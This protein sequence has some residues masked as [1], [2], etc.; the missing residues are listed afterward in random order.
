MPVDRVK[1]VNLP[2]HEQRANRAKVKA[3]SKQVA[4]TTASTQ[5]SQS[6]AA[7]PA[8]TVMTTCFSS[9]S[10]QTDSGTLI[11]R[12][13]GPTRAPGVAI[14][15]E[16]TPT[17]PA[18]IEQ[19]ASNI[20]TPQGPTSTR[21]DN[22]NEGSRFV[23][24]GTTTGGHPFGQPY[25]PQNGLQSSLP[26]VADED[27]YI[28][29]SSDSNPFD[30]SNANWDNMMLNS[31]IGALGVPMGTYSSSVGAQ[32]PIVLFNNASTYSMSSVPN[33]SFF[34]PA[35]LP[36][37]HSSVDPVLGLPT[38]P[39]LQGA[40]A[41]SESQQLLPV[42]QPGLTAARDPSLALPQFA[43]AIPTTDYSYNPTI[44]IPPTSGPSTLAV[45]SQPPALASSVPIST[46]PQTSAMQ[47]LDL[48]ASR[49]DSANF[50]QDLAHKLDQSDPASPNIEPQEFTPIRGTRSRAQS[51]RHAQSGS[52]SQHQVRMSPGYFA[53]IP[54]PHA[55]FR[56]L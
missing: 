48:V 56:R 14:P 33:S 36:A 32:D 37:S 22:A 45:V 41:M 46:Q 43:S 20:A 50:A 17:E 40:Y 35:G 16:P 10:S 2:V 28:L 19:M 6:T 34:P 42:P 1:P 5:P 53:G 30:F 51:G 26:A 47:D 49:Q 9:T 27:A 31:G 3:L 23:E 21:V 18:P 7:P 44:N 54:H 12:S 4:A 11:T 39:N 8:N 13:R 25:D 24:P 29:L 55:G 15:T 52:R 38:L